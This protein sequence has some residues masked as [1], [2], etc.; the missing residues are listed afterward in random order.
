MNKAT[1]LCII[2]CNCIPHDNNGILI[3]AVAVENVGEINQWNVSILRRTQVDGAADTLDA[4]VVVAD[5]AP[6]QASK[7]VQ[8]PLRPDILVMIAQFV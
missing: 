3:A 1:Y 2:D 7:V 4:V 5:D 6:V 8:D